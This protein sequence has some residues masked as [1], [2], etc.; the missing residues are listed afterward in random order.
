MNLAKAINFINYFFHL[1]QFD[2]FRGI[3]NQIIKINNQKND[4]YDYGNSFFY[5]SMPCINLGGLRDTKS[6]IEVL[7]LEQ[8][9]KDKTILDIGT[10]I[11]AILLNI[12]ND[13]KN[14]IGI[15]HNPKLIDI[16]NKIKHY[17]NI[18]NLN[19]IC[20]DFNDYN[21]SNKFEIILSLANHKTYDKGITNTEEYF[22]KIKSLINDNGF[23]FLESHPSLYED[24]E[25][26]KL[27]VKNLLKDYTLIQE[28]AYKFGNIFDNSRRYVVL[29]KI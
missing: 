14:A 8:Y 24:K 15:E 22:N 21:F 1:I 7:K 20:G 29:K 19:F 17:L 28:G 4:F 23:L 10:N 12:N 6:R 2:K 27:L 16:A 18:N 5:Q 13:F 11:G 25:K 9:T 26:F 3:R